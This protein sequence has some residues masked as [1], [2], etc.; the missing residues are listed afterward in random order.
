MIVK[1]STSLKDKKID[2]VLKGSDWSSEKFGAAF[3]NRFEPDLKDS[4]M[5]LITDD[6]SLVSKYGNRDRDLARI[7]YIGNSSDIDAKTVEDVW[8]ANE[9]PSDLLIRLHRFLDREAE[10]FEG[11][12]Y[13]DILEAGINSVPDLIWVKD[14]KGAHLIVNDSFCNAVNK[15]KKEIHGRGHYFI[16][17]ITPEEYASGEYVCM[18]SETETMEAGRTCVFD[19]PLK[20]GDRMKQLQTYKTPLKDPFGNIFGTIGIAKDVTDFKNMG[21]E[22]HLLVEN[23]PAP[24]LMCDINWDSIQMNKSFRYLTGISTEDAFNYKDWVNGNLQ[25]LDGE[26]KGEFYLTFNG[27]KRTIIIFEND[28][29]DYFGNITGHF[30]SIRDITFE[31][32][33]E[34]SILHAANHDQLTGLYSRR[35]YYDYMKKHRNEKMLLICMDLDN[36]KYINDNFGHIKG[37][38]ILQ[39][40][41]E[42]ISEAFPDGI[43]ARI[44]G[45][46]FATVMLG[47]ID[48]E[49]ISSR[50]RELE[51]QINNLIKHDGPPLGISIGAADNTN[52]DSL[53]DFINI[54][55]KRMYE[56]KKIHHRKWI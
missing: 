35:Y 20:V 28:I 48:D 50:S 6:T 18:E 24:L 10:R 8:P 19:E 32:A 5:L 53:D 38:E 23:I 14:A 54:S 51:Y 15:T 39:K 17:D 52:C 55:D 36:F 2:A 40:V 27:E 37:D 29:R 7:V 56:M 33:F 1:I 41:A 43:T 49:D 13:R 30:V 45:D 16:W 3:V 11:W 26:H 47:E 12:M 42:K 34:H 31:R 25:P 22:L 9:T 46:E 4:Y 21:I 44:G